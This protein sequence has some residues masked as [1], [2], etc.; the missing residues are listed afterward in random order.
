MSEIET[1]EQ[2]RITNIEGNRRCLYKE[3]RV[4]DKRMAKQA[5]GTTSEAESPG[6]DSSAARDFFRSKKEESI[7]K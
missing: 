7:G 1:N 4:T 2:R 6:F 5:S 3:K